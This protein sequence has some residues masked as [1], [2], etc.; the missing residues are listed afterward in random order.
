MLYF[1]GDIHGDILRRIYSFRRLGVRREEPN[2]LFVCGDFGLPWSPHSHTKEQRVLDVAEKHLNLYNVTLYFVDGNH[3]NFD[4]LYAIP[5]EGDGTR[6]LRQHIRH[7]PRGTLHTI[8]GCDVF[9]FGGAMSTDRGIES[10]GRDYWVQE[11]PTYSESHRGLETLSAAENVD[12]VVSHA[13]PSGALS[14]MCKAG[15]WFEAARFTDP[16]AKALE[17]YRLIIEVRFPHAHW[18]YGHYHEN[19]TYPPIKWL[20]NLTYTCIYERI[21]AINEQGVFLKRDKPREE[22]F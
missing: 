18:F 21:Y 11:L 13:A 2:A 22:R 5:I 4:M 15:I 14:M 9:A 8:N 3:E 1:T 16:A 7:M 6:H 19:V 17:E 20:T 10:L 12:F